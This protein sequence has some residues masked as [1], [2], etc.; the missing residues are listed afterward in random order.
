MTILQWLW[1]PDATEQTPLNNFTCRGLQKVLLAFLLTQEVA[2]DCPETRQDH[3]QCGQQ[4][5]HNPNY[6]MTSIGGARLIPQKYQ[7]AVI[8]T[9]ESIHEE[10]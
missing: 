6:T 10:I 4:N 7:K 5:L 1:C 9:Y 3:E 2:S 8:N